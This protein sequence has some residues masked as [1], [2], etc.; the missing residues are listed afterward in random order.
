M[1]K[2]FKQ[3][4]IALDLFIFIFIISYT[5]II[6]SGVVRYVAL[7]AFQTYCIIF[8]RKTK[9]TINFET[10]FLIVALLISMLPSMF[11]SKFFFNSIIKI[12]TILDLLILSCVILPNYLSNYDIEDVIKNIFFTMAITI[13]CLA[14]VYKDDYSISYD[15]MRIGSSV[16][17]KAGFFHANYFAMFCFMATL[18]D[19]YLFTNKL[20]KKKILCILLLPLVFLIYKSGSR[21]SLYTLIIFTVMY[22]F[23]IFIKN[24]K[25]K[26]L[27][28]FGLLFSVLIL[29]L[30]NF[31]KLSSISYSNINRL[32]SYRLDYFMSAFKSLKEENAIFTGIG[33]FTNSTTFSNDMVLI[34][35]GYFNYIYQYGVISFL[36]LI[37]F[38]LHEYLSANFN[39][40]D[41]NNKYKE[42]LKCFFISFLIYG[43]LEN[44]ILN[45]GSLFAIIA[46]SLIALER[47][48]GVNKKHEN[49]INN[50]NIQ[51]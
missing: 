23:N 8:K 26:K 15:I 10:A 24:Y 39:A 6:N 12:I 32:L 31:T 7:I 13:C 47:M 9:Y 16:R 14:I 30:V 38:L 42:F 28:R 34:D 1:K 17:F 43:L 4:P 19:L 50:S 27:I 5:K 22:S 11:I 3:I 29:I 37:L 41:E 48:K 44:I 40:K 51:C 18:F 33:A 20:K 35:N 49:I 36:I 45:I 2:S 21:T 46:Y 25:L